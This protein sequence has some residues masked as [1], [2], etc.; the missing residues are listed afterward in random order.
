[1]PYRLPYGKDVVLDLP[2]VDAGVSPAPFESTPVTIAAGDAKVAHDRLIPTNL[3]GKTIA[4]TSGGTAEVRPGYTLTG[5]T[6]AATCIVMGVRVTSGTW[7]G[8]DAAGSLF[9]RS[10]S[11]TFQSE[12]LN[13]TA[14][15]NICTIGAALDAAGLFKHIAGGVYGFGIPGSQLLGARGYLKVQDQTAT[16][17][18][19]DTA[20]AFET[21]D[22]P[23]AADPMGCLY[24]GT[25]QSVTSTTLVAEASADG[26]ANPLTGDAAIGP[27]LVLLIESA[28]VGA[29][30][31]V[32]I[33]SFT[34]ASLT[35]T[36]RHAFPLTP[37]GTI[38]YKVYAM[39]TVPANVVR[40]ANGTP[41]A[42]GGSAPASRIGIT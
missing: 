10:D 37:T 9:V 32:P 29:G 17:E 28:T 1:M 12:N 19:E 16:E 27:N 3:S 33:L 14:Q 11:G 18:W 42:V 39:A 36:L 8:G 26:I 2:L 40:V 31:V 5:A 41:L 34:Y 22:H 20:I 25:A 21:I 7:A 15:S 13:A 24:A 35:F 23:Y 30:Q 4:F 6:S 38:T